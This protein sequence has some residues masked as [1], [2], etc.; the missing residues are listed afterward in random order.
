MSLPKPRLPYS[1]PTQLPD[2]LD[3]SLPQPEQV[4]WL[5]LDWDA[6]VPCPPTEGDRK[7]EAVFIDVDVL[8][9]A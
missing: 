5:Q 4:N 8:V 9:G 6:R 2:L 7:D 1:R 3:Q